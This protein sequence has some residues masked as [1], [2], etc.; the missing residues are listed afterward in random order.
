[1]AKFTKNFDFKSRRDHQ[2]NSNERRV[3]ES[4]D[5]KGLS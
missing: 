4:V 1:M 2:K 3:Y 5:E